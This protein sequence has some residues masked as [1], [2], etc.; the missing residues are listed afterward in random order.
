VEMV[1]GLEDGITDPTG[2]FEF[3]EVGRSPD[4]SVRFLENYWEGWTGEKITYHIGET[5]SDAVKFYGVPSILGRSGGLK[6]SHLK[7][8]C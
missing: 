5:S 7:W 4:K 3:N 8:A 1:E 2:L 6:F